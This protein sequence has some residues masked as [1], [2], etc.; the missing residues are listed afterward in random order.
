MARKAAEPVLEPVLDRPPGD[1]SAAPELLLSPSIVA[2]HSF[3]HESE[4]QFARL[5][6]FYGVAWRY[7][8]RSFPLREQDGR[9]VEAFTPDFYLPDSDLFIELTTLKQGL[10]TEKHRKLRLLRATYPDVN[11]KLLHRRD[12]LRLL[13]KYGFGPLSE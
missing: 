7:E 10:V 2:P 11:I 9:V 13:A 1:D 4:A 12:Y 8:S 3:A 6:D 5:L